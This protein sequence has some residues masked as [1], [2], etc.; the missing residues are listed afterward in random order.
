MA[1]YATV[2]DAELLCG[3]VEIASYCDRNNDGALDFSSFSQHLEIASREMDSYLLGR[4]P[5]PLGTPPEHFKKLCVDIA[6]YN[7]A[8]APPT[9]TAT[10]TKRR[11]DAI[12]YMRMIAVGKIKLETSSNTTSNNAAQTPDTATR[13]TLQSL[14]RPGIRTFTRK[15]TRYL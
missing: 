1:A 4:Y 9:L 6:I 5:L 7:A 14:A 15:S 2:A 12:E 11:D 10:M 13:S 3:S 8:G